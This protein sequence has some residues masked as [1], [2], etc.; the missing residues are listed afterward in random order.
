MKYAASMHGSTRVT[1]IDQHHRDGA[2]VEF[3]MR[4]ER[5]HLAGARH[6]MSLPASEYREIK[7]LAKAHSKPLIHDETRS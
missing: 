4:G 6:V 7:R 3:V 5:L 2:H 1:V